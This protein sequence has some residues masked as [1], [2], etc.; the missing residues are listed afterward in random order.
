[1]STKIYFSENLISGNEN[2]S[3]PNSFWYYTGGANLKYDCY[4]SPSTTTGV[5]RLI[6]H[7]VNTGQDINKRI[8]ASVFKYNKVFSGSQFLNSGIFTGYF[9]PKGPTGINSGHCN[10]LVIK[11]CDQS[12]NLRKVLYSGDQSDT[13]HFSKYDSQGYRL[14]YFNGIVGTGMANDGDSLFF[15]IGTKILHSGSHLN[16]AASPRMRFIS[17]TGYSDSPFIN[18]NTPQNVT[19]KNNYIAINVDYKFR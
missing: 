7:P 5:E 14:Q 8:I 6:F 9:I 18:Y 11:V 15:E 10:S 19:G 3:A 4:S 1:M 2:Y 12:G 13:S 17:Y 16:T